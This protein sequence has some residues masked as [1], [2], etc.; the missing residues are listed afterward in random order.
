[1]E[2]HQNAVRVVRVALAVPMATLFSY[3]CDDFEESDIGRLVDVPFGR[4]NQKKLGVIVEKGD[5]ESQPHKLKKIAAI[6]REL[7]AFP[8]DYLSFCAF[9]AL[10]R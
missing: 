3:E 6:H 7:P 2:N 5:E 9:A 10:Y 1:M 8:P 4:G